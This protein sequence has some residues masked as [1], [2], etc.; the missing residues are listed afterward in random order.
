MRKLLLAL[1][2]LPSLVSAADIIASGV[3]EENN[4]YTLYVYARIDAP[5][6]MVHAAITDFANL[7]TINPSIEES[8][9]LMQTP[10][11]QRVR[12][13]VRVCILIFCKRVVQ[14]QDVR[15]PD[16]YTIEATMVPGAGDFLSGSARWTLQAQNGVTRLRFIEVFV[17]DFWV[18]PLIGTWMI[19][20]K[21]VEEVE[22]TARHIEQQ[23]RGV[24]A[25]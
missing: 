9:V 14:V 24:V 23:A 8:Q 10:D 19:E 11:Q 5:L 18:P 6:P 13:V 2:L 16:D 4:T 15:E 21:L 12:T 1:L 7:A 3:T 17:P 25:D 22:L 20:D